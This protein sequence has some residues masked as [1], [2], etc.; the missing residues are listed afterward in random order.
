MTVRLKVETSHTLRGLGEGSVQGEGSGE[1]VDGTL[2]SD[3]K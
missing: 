2:M 1:G 3:R